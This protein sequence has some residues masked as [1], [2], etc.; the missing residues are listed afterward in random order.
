MVF[1]SAVFLLLFL[2]VV[3]ALSLVG[4][5]RWRNPLLL[6]ASLGFYAWGELAYTVVL[7]ASIGFNYAA[8]LALERWRHRGLLVVAVGFN[9]GMLIWFK[10]AVWFAGMLGTMLGWAGLPPPPPLDIHM[11]IGI[12][13]FTFQAI[14]YVVDVWRRTVPAARNAVDYAMY[15]ALFPQLIAGPIVRY[16]DVAGDVATSQRPY[17]LWAEGA[18]RFIRGL[19]KKVLLAN[20]LGAVADGWYNVPAA[21]LS[22]GQAW[23]ATVAF[24][25]QLYF[26]FSAYS[27]MAIGIGRMLGIRFLEN[28]NL[29]FSAISL[30]D[31][32]QRWH[33]SL[34]TWLRDYL[35]F[36]LL[37]RRPS[38]LRQ[39]LVV[40]V[41]F[42]LCGLWHGASSMFVI[43]G[44]WNALILVIER[45]FWGDTLRRLGPAV[46]WIYTMAVLVPSFVL[47][48]SE[49]MHQ[50]ST[51]L[52][53]LV[54]VGGPGSAVQPM[55]SLHWVVLF[56][57]PLFALPCARW[58]EAAVK[59]TCTAEVVAYLARSLAL[60]RVAA[61]A[62]ILAYSL[63]QVAQQT[64]NPFIYFRF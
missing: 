62:L 15:K 6:L 7:L 16:R 23:L 56:A 22:S 45:A 61:L 43:W 41:V 37:G 46:G 59:A 50:A 38:R 34:S 44:L 20:P 24:A 42:F 11:P 28:F 35:F 26:D 30:T 48:R 12:S 31:F 33:I 49:D 53:A 9:L 4:G 57:A 25:L 27:D 58:I 18:E 52:A 64:Y 39:K 47:F 10:Y 54:G 17:H 8:G 29:P 51:V 1:S 3:L 13:F 21:D 19:G 5:T 2:P 40:V 36:P 32:W 55:D 63:A 14:S 60:P